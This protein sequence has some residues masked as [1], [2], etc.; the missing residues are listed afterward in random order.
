MSDSLLVINAG[1]SSLKFQVYELSDEG[2]PLF[3]YGGQV[4]GIGAGHA[5][6]VVQDAEKTVLVERDLSSGEGADLTSAQQAVAAWLRTKIDRP[7]R[8]VGHRIVHGGTDFFESIVIDDDILRRLD[9]LAPLAPLHQNNNLAPVH[10]I[11][12]H[13]PQITQVACFDTAFHRTHSQVVERFALPQALY[14]RGVR[15][16]GFHGLSYEYIAQRIRTVLP[17]R[18]Q[19]RVIAAH[20][21]A[22]ASACAMLDGRSVETTMGFTALDGLPMST[23]PGSLDAGVVLWMLEEGMN[24]DEIQHLLYKESG[25]KGLSGISGDVRELLAS[26]A[27]SARLALDYFAYRV[28]QSITSLC[29]CLQGLDAIVFTAGVGENSPPTRADICAHLQWLGVVLDPVRNAA[30]AELISAKNSR[31]AVYVV[32]TNEERVIAQHTAE[33][34]ARL[35]PII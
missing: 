10:V 7:P 28:A 34:I 26:K 23:R 12:E 13:W 14:D 9:A 29:V 4:S 16:Y 30:K 2:L 8:A 31:V 19:R 20:L 6:F 1:S 5:R 3:S 33:T 22:G 21:G 25:L 32:P 18:A 35:N 27:P 15:R 24:H 17:P 11:H